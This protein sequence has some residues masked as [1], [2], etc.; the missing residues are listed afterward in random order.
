[1]MS[2]DVGKA[3][4]GGLSHST[5]EESLATHFSKFGEI[6]NTSVMRDPVTKV[7][8]GF[9]FVEFKDPNVVELVA[10]QEHFLDGKKVDPKQAMVPGKGPARAVSTDANPSEYVGTTKKIFVG[11]IAPGTTEDFMKDF[12]SSR[13]GAVDE[14]VFMYDR[15]T[16]KPRGF[17][18]VTFES[19][20]TVDKV[21]KDHF[22]EIKGKRV[23]CKKAQP[24]PGEKGY[25]P[26]SFPKSSVGRGR[27]HGRGGGM[28]GPQGY[29]G[30]RGFNAPS[31]NYG[32]GQDYQGYDDYNRSYG[33][34]QYGQQGGYQAQGYP[35]AGGYDA[36]VQ[37]PQHPMQPQ[38]PVPGQPPQ[39]QVPPQQPGQMQ[40]PQPYGQGYQQAYGAQGYGTPGYGG[41]QQSYGAQSFP[42]QSYPT[43]SQYATQA[44]AATPT[45]A[46]G[47]YGQ[48]QSNYGPSKA[49]YSVSG[50]SSAPAAR[51][52]VQAY[53]QPQQGYD[54]SGANATYN[55]PQT[56]P[57][58]TGRGSVRFQPY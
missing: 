55:Q 18:F 35:R 47:S 14:V 4:V 57:Q 42:Q 10:R 24:R 22:I 16:N 41:G 30:G 31:A 21:V 53:G 43:A 32:Y 58:G 44:Q 48:E 46:M 37:Q 51:P 25:V 12:F 36:Y 20:E 33:Q 11:G 39:P 45:Q 50:Y 29:G 6:L 1:M 40:P 5:T 56:T 7:P 15:S 13:Y 28:S 26:G 52:G 54:T 8:R 34:Y 49:S 2:V 27:G 19:E 38:H 3:F 9:G 23:E 17:G